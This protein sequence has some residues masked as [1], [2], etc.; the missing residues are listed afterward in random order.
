[1]IYA[2]LGSSRSL[3]MVPES[4]T[5]LITAVAIGPLAAG[6]PARYAGLAASLALLVGVLSVCA[7]LARLG[8]IADLLSRPVLVGYLTGVGLIMIAGQLGRVTGV[9]VS[10]STFAAELSSFAHGLGTSQPATV[11]LATSVL[12][13]CCVPWARRSADHGPE[14]A[15]WA[16]RWQSSPAAVLPAAGEPLDYGQDRCERVDDVLQRV[17]YLLQLVAV[18]ALAAKSM[19]EHDKVG[20]CIFERTGGVSAVFHDRW[21]TFVS[22]AVRVQGAAGHAGRPWPAVAAVLGGPDSLVP[23]PELRAIRSSPRIELGRAAG[24][25]GFHGCSVVG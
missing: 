3:S 10:G 19:A 21:D 16:H 25:P 8:F 5:A 7:G 6:S 4:T 20:A 11:A 15:D 14:M 13:A 22:M 12:R 9:P 1:M 18:R 2:A 17:S 23:G 24:G